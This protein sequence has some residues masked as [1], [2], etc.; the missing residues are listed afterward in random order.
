MS[1]VKNIYINSSPGFRDIGGTSENFTITKTVS[2]FN[3]VPK[4]VKLLS[5]RMPF[6]WSNITSANNAFILIENPG[7]V[8]HP[9]TTIAPGHYSGTTLAPALQNALNTIPGKLYTYTV[10][11][12]T[13][14]FKY[15]ISATGLFQLNFAVPDS[16]APALGFNETITASSV[17]VESPNVAI[18]LPD[19]EIFVASNLVGGVDNGVIPYFTGATNDLHI[20]AVIPI[21]SCY[22]GVIEYRVSDSEPWLNASQSAFSMIPNNSSQLTG[23]DAILHFSLFFLSGI[24]VNLFGANWSA[25]ILLEF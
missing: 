16:I 9:T 17:S 4:R 14:T 24:P 13:T 23:T 22:G 21:T 11:Y 1:N 19:T 7:P 20:L 18:I 25:N 15:T 12:N 8:V 10:T 2:P 5:A 6:V 3:M